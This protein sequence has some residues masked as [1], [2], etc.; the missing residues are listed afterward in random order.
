MAIG[1]FS[2]YAARNYT[3]ALRTLYIEALRKAG[4]PEE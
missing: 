2:A 1:S 4:L 3:P